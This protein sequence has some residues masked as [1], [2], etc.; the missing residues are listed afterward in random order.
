RRCLARA[1][2]RRCIPRP[3]RAAGHTHPADGPR[4]AV[5]GNAQQHR[6]RRMT[7]RPGPMRLA[8]FVAVLAFAASSAGLAAEQPSPAMKAEA[9]AVVGA[10]YADYRRFCADVQPGGGRVLACLAKRGTE[11]STACR[12]VLPGAEALKGSAAQTGVLPK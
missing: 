4:P 7:M 1:V 10:C 11:L 2:F 12:D 8:P 6:C 5:G 9:R 3:L